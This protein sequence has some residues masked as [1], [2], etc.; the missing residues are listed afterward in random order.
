MKETIQ[1]TTAIKNIV[2]KIPIF[3]ISNN[4][5][6]NIGLILHVSLSAFDL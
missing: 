3:L 5:V 2:L 6:T 4:K 1:Y